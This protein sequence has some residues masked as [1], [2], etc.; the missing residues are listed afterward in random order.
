MT[1]EPELDRE[2]AR[3][4]A[5]GA[6]WSRTSLADRIE[7][8]DELRAR[9]DAVAEPWVRTAL[10]QEGLTASDPRAGEE[11][12]GGPY[13]VA[14]QLRL[15]ART[16]RDLDRHGRPPVVP[17]PGWIACACCR[18]SRSIGSFSNA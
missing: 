3:V 17:R 1:L 7:L 6:R 12:F 15:F 16:L 8:L 10:E 4:A 2:V 11:W 14:R 9:F 13:F 18:A 5:A